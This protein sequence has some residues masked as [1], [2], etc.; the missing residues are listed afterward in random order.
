MKFSNIV[1]SIQS[2]LKSLTRSQ[3]EEHGSE[4]LYSSTQTNSPRCHQC[5]LKAS[6]CVCGRTNVN[7]WQ[8]TVGP[9]QQ[10][11]EADH[12]VNACVRNHTNVDAWSKV[13]H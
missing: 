6:R 12:V 13:F 3:L 11:I 8:D 5:D 2:S 9:D 4:E 10:N 7:A 1:G